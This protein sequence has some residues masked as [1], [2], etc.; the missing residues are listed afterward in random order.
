MTNLKLEKTMMKEETKNIH[1][2]MSDEQRAMTFKPLKAIAAGLCI[3]TLAACEMAE[4]HSQAID[5]ETITEVKEIDTSQVEGR[6]ALCARHGIY[7]KAF[8]RGRPK[9]EG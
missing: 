8:T 7:C 3:V 5:M 9:A 1:S 4:S 6:D 2:E